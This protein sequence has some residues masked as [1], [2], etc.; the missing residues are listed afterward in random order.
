MALSVVSARYPQP[1]R[2][3]STTGLGRRLSRF[4]SG[5]FFISFIG[6]IISGSAVE[7]QESRFCDRFAVSCQPQSNRPQ[8]AAARRALWALLRSFEHL[9]YW[10][11][12]AGGG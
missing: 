8:H 6:R 9:I 12:E 5:G 4:G 7:A 2:M 3:H 11:R 1:S 10:P